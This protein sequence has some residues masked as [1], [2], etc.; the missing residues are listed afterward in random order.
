MRAYHLI[1][2]LTFRTFNNRF[3]L[4]IE[5]KFSKYIKAIKIKNVYVMVIMTRYNTVF[6]VDAR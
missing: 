1:H 6:L 5:L 3:F 4:T 2:A